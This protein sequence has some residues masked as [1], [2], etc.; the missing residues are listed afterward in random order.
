MTVTAYENIQHTSATCVQEIQN[1][2][3]ECE[4]TKPGHSVKAVKAF[5]PHLLTFVL[6]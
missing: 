5:K 1:N 3:C 6:Y 2:I 4:K